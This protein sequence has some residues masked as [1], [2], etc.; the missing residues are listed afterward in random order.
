MSPGV[1]TELSIARHLREESSRGFSA[2]HGVLASI[3]A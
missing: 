3:E 1:Y 2:A